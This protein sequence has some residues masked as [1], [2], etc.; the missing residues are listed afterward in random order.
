M[1]RERAFAL[2]VGTVLIVLGL[3]GSLGTSLV[4]GPDDTGLV[5]TGPGHDIAHL[6]LGALYLH[7]GL[8]LGGRLQAD[9]LLV[10]GAI[11]LATG[12]LSLLSPD[13]FGLYGAPTGIVDQLTH[14]VLGV[15]SIGLG[16]VARSALL[17]HERRVATRSR[18]SRR[19]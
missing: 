3:A 6:I 2:I 10:L 17:A 12:I 8:V 11:L 9:G 19:R 7:V 18:P 5:V 1:G 14:L 13:L 15:I 16:F 4:G